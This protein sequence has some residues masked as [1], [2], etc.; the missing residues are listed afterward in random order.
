MSSIRT[1]LTHTQWVCATHRIGFVM[2]G[3]RDLLMSSLVVMT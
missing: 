1:I 3:P 2:W